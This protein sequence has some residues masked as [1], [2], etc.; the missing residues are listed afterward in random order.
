MYSQYAYRK[1]PTDLEYH[2]IINEVK[3]IED[4]MDNLELA[5][6]NDLKATINLMARY[7]RN[8]KGLEKGVS[9]NHILEYIIRY[10]R[11]KLDTELISGFTSVYK[12]IQHACSCQRF[13]DNQ[14]YKPLRD[15]D[16]VSITQKEIDTIKE[17]DTL[18]EQEVA[19]AILCFTKM[20][21]E[22]NRRQGRK[23]NNLFYVDIS[24]IR[25][26]IG[27]KKGTKNEVALT[28]NKLKEKGLLDVI[29][30]RDKYGDAMCKTR[31]PF[32]TNQCKFVDDGE[33]VLFVDCFD[34]LN[35]TWQF[36][37]GKKTVKKCACGRYFDA[38][39]NRQKQCRKCNP[40]I[41]EKKPKKKTNKKSLRR[42]GK[43]Q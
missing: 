18:E 14:G 11:E 1:A 24:V 29:E 2:Y 13:K 41:S 43:Q 40:K 31:Q 26:C 20:Y 32:I 22:T 19:F 3:Y 4:V 8:Y 25:R 33:E 28:M 5:Y 30:N 16:G 9:E 38:N 6:D 15:F 35:L 23:I 39:S 21:N 7:Y 27:W 36:I 34:T 17:L 37:L 10:Y 42:M 12:R